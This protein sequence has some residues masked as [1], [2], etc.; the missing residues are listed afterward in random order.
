MK[1][2]GQSLKQLLIYCG[3]S[4][5]MC[6]M[7][8]QEGGGRSDQ[9]V[10]RGHSQPIPHSCLFGPQSSPSPFDWRPH[11]SFLQPK[12]LPPNPTATTPQTRTRPNAPFYTPTPDRDLHLTPRPTPELRFGPR[13]RPLYLWGRP[14]PRPIGC[15]LIRLVCRVWGQGQ[16]ARLRMSV[17][18][19][20]SVG[21]GVSASG[22]V[23]VRGDSEGKGRRVGVRGRG[24]VRGRGGREGDPWG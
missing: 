6:Q 12:P 9:P 5:S 4:P 21:V 18:V 16:G 10:L 8:N 1:K 23:R 7:A 14:E 2:T 22:R 17:R 24:T 11:P 19:K 13:H 3:I 15:G 20:G